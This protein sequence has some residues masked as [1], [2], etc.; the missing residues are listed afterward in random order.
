MTHL[1]PHQQNNLSVSVIIPTFNR[2]RFVGE[3]IQSILDQ[4]H[5]VYEIIV[6][7]DGSKDE[8]LKVL[9]AFGDRIK[10]IEKENGGKSTALNIAMKAA[11]GEVIWIFDDDDVAVPNALEL[12]INPLRS[13]DECGF[14]FG[15]H[16]HLVDRGAGRFEV[17]P[18]NLRID[19]SVDVKLS[20]L[21]RCYIFQPALLVRRRCYDAVG[22]FNEGL[23]R[24]QDYEMLIRLSRRFKGSPV[25]KV[26]FH[27]RQHMGVR[28]T[29]NAPV[30]AD[31][32]IATWIRNDGL[33]FGRIYDEYSLADYLPGQT[34]GDISM[35][36]RDQLAALLERCCIM[37]RKGMW[38]EAAADLGAASDLYSIHPEIHLDR[39]LLAP[40]SRIFMPYSYAEHTVVKSGDLF[41]KL[42]TSASSKFRRRVTQAL[43]RPMFIEM[44]L[45]IRSFDVRRFL[46]YLRKLA[47]VAAMRATGT[48]H[49][50]STTTSAGGA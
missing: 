23:V 21:E 1:Q 2:C 33:I 34:Q 50:L 9:A 25:R 24:S 43:F 16:D 11:S 45:A 13:D 4:T 37:A 31:Q 29:A 8:T 20:I 30:R 39:P 46:V 18:Q 26:V 44:R 14:S 32:M 41:G 35:S 38:D 12:L 49:E 36:P 19:E 5:P 22:P 10:V 42:R 28:G 6:V 17:V 48:T 40:L 47:R 3:A 7:D 15:S 27:Q